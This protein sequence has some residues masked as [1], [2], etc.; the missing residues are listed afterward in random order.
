MDARS[1]PQ[2]DDRGANTEFRDKEGKT[3]L[4]H[5][6]INQDLRMIQLLLKHDANIDAFDNKGH[7]ALFYIADSSTDTHRKLREILM[8]AVIQ[9]H[10]PLLQTLRPPISEN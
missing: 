10:G 2:G 4:I 3:A 5:A 9:K 7:K 8:K 6:A 1:V